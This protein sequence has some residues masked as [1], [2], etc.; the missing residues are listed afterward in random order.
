MMHTLRHHALDR[1]RHLYQLPRVRMG[2]LALGGFLQRCESA[3][4]K[5]MA[6]LKVYIM[7][8]KTQDLIDGPLDWAAM[9]AEEMV[10]G[11]PQGYFSD[12]VIRGVLAISTDWAQGGPIIEREQMDIK[13]VG[14]NNCRASIE[15]LDEEHFEAFGPTPLIAAMRCF[16]ASRLGDEVDVPA[17]LI[18]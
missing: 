4:N 1:V 5:A 7:K 14:I 16:V 2:V 3:L 17:N 8:I 11:L 10:R 6:F 13:W 18:V 15:W 12:M 9:R